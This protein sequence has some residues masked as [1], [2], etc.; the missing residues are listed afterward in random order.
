MGVIYVP[1]TKDLYFA[2]ENAY[3][4]SNFQSEITDL[5]ELTTSSNQLPFIQ[6]R[7]NYIVVGSRSHMSEETEAFINEQK[8][9][10]PRS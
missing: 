4:V 8:E 10:H 5:N 2:D 7:S 6:V 9:K 3:K 1:V